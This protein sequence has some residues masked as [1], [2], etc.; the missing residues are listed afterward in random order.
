MTRRF[1]TTTYQDIDILWEDGFKKD[2]CD[3]GIVFMQNEPGFATFLAT[4]G[5]VGDEEPVARIYSKLLAIEPQNAI[6]EIAEPCLM[7]Y[8][9]DDHIILR[10]VNLMPPNSPIDMTN[11]LW[12][13]PLARDLASVL[14]EIGVTKLFTMTSVAVEGTPLEGDGH[15]YI[16]YDFQ[17]KDVIGSLGGGEL[18]LTT[19]SW[20]LG[21]LFAKIG[22]DDVGSIL[23]LMKSETIMGIDEQAVQYALDFYHQSFDLSPDLDAMNEIRSILNSIDEEGFYMNPFDEDEFDANNSGGYHA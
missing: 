7:L 6:P 17:K 23:M 16:A 19:P 4:M 11:Y 15:P 3:T 18:A 5:V 1:D 9:I 22:G 12:H 20:L 10:L 2:S 14:C 8:N 21:E 13:Y